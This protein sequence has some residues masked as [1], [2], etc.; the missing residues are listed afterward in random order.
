MFLLGSSVY[1][2]LV[3]TSRAEKVEKLLKCETKKVEVTQWLLKLPTE[4]SYIVSTLNQSNSV[5]R[6]T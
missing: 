1:T 6:T 5:K 2:I 4:L 3:C